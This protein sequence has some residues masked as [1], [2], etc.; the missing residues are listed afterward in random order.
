MDKQDSIIECLPRMH[1]N[2]GWCHMSDIPVPKRQRC[3]CV[4]GAVS[5]SVYG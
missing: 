1:T 3:V 2:W 5:F 4:G